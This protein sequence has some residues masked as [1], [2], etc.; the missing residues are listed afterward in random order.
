MNRR[1]VTGLVVAAVGVLAVALAAATLPSAVDPES[2]V[3]G[4]GDTG[5][6]E[7]T[8]P[9]FGTPPPA[10]RPVDALEI[11]FLSEL[12]ALLLLLAALAV[13]VSAVRNWRELVPVAIG[14]V[15]LVALLLVAFLLLGEL[16]V[17]PGESANESLG[18]DGLG[19]GDGGDGSIG[20]SDTTPLPFVVLLVL[21]VAVLGMLFAV[22][23]S[24]S[25]DPESG[26][27]DLVDGPDSDADRTAIGRVAGRAAD[28][29][30]RGDDVDN[31]VVRAWTEM[32]A[33][34]DVDRP[35]TTTPGEFATAAVDAGMDPDDVRELT[36]LFEDVRYGEYSP[37]ADRER[38]AVRVFRRIER[39]Y[40]DDE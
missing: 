8:G 7:G 35:E 36:R 39:A 3:G 10:D 27:M 26:S 25:A 40:G 28:R 17:M 6:G 33:L 32:T 19:G 1:P 18:G 4:G 23:R 29:I 2:G 12:L 5:V 34:L 16:S 9:G 13:L 21:T 37:T 11:P 15:A 38:R 20:S 14:V 22:A 24:S 31:D 30:E